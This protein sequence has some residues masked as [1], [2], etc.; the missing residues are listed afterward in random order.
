MSGEQASLNTIDI[1]FTDVPKHIDPYDQTDGTNVDNYAVTGPTSPDRLIQAIEYLGGNTIRLWFDGDLVAGEAYEIVVT[2]VES[3]SDVPMP[4]TIDLVAYGKD[5]PAVPLRLEKADSWDI[6]NPQVERDSQ[7]W[8]L[9]TLGTDETGDVAVE[10]R[11]AALRKRIIRRCT[12]R[13]NGFAHLDGYGLNPGVKH[14]VTARQLRQLQQ[15][16][17]NQVREEPDVVSAR[18]IVRQQSPG[19][20]WLSLKVVDQKGPFTIE[21]LLG[22]D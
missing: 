20:V 22:D 10:A 18:A 14:L 16:A 11:R 19:V 5:R 9:G 1:V 17:R 13:L 4:Q 8:P 3:E 6:A 15:D 12:T 2:N 21:T 7:G